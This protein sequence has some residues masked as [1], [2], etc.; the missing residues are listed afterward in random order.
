VQE[1]QEIV[2]RTQVAR[3]LGEPCGAPA[4]QRLKQRLIDYVH[5]L[6][7]LRIQSNNAFF[8]SIAMLQISQHGSGTV[9]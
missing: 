6:K 1:H 4:T 5:K 9:I 2:L 3:L 8:S 7:T